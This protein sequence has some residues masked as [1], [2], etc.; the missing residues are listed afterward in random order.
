MFAVVSEATVV[1]D[2]EA[3]WE[4]VRDEMIELMRSA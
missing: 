2:S 4:T 1:V 3:I